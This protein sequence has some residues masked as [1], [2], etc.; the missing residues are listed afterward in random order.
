R[1]HGR[2]PVRRGIAIPWDLTGVHSMETATVMAPHSVLPVVVFELELAGVGIKVVQLAITSPVDS[3]IQLLTRLV[4]RESPAQQVKE[5][6]LAECAI[7]RGLEAAAD[8]SNQWRS[9]LCLSCEDRLRG[10][11]VCLDETVPFVGELDVRALDHGQPEQ[12]RSIHE[13]KEILHVEGTAL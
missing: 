11:D 8:G 3:Q 12:P 10:V 5:E 2:R 9:C 7:V 4:S 13:R 6:T 1:G